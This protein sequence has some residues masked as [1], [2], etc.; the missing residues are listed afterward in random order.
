[1]RKGCIAFPRCRWGSTS[2][3]LLDWISDGLERKRRR[4]RG[5]GH[6]GQLR[7]ENGG[8]EE[9]VTVTG[10]APLINVTSSELKHVTRAE[11]IQSVP[12]LSRDFTGLVTLTPGV[13][14]GTPPP[15]SGARQGTMSFAGAT[16]G[17]NITILVDGADNRDE[18]LGGVLLNMTLE[19]IEEFKVSS[20]RFDAVE[21]KTGGAVISITTKSGGNT[22]HGSGFFQGR[23]EALTAKDYFTKQSNQAE[24]PY[25]RKQFG[26]NFGGPIVRNRMFYFGA[27]ERVVEN[28]ETALNAN[29]ITQLQL[30]ATVVPGVKVGTAMPSRSANGEPSGR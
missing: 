16:T 12:L 22:L 7:P 11:Q 30:L 8:V 4:G 5:W 2:R 20:S 17:R 3:G 6:H 10:E 21:G 13:R 15:P 29:V 23:N 1:M 24:T 28:R 19:G 26:G 25:N 18:N 9:S 27:L 14:T